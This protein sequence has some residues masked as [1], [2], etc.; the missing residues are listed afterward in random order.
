MTTIIKKDPLLNTNTFTQSKV[1]AYIKQHDEPEWLAE[2][3]QSA[4]QAFIEIPMPTIQDEAWRRTNLRKVK[5]NKFAF[6]IPSSLNPVSE[7]S[8]LP[9]KLRQYL[10]EGQATAGRLLIINGQVIYRELSN[11]IVEQGLLFSDLQ[12]AIKRHA[13]LVQ[14]HLMDKCVPIDDSKFAAL[15]AAFW[16]NGVFLYVPQGVLVKHP[17]QV[18]ILT[19]GESACSIHRTLIIAESESKVDYIEETTTMNEND[20]G[21]NVGMVE[22]IAK[23]A[24]QVRYVDVQQLGSKVYNFNTKRALVHA[25]A[26]MIWDMGEFGGAISKT[27][28]DSQLIGDGGTM[29]CYGVYLLDGKQ[30]LDID[31]LMRHVG[32]STSGDLLLHGALKDKARSVF[33]GLIKIDPSGQL[34]NSYLKNQSLL[35]DSTAR[36]DAI[37]ALEIE[38]DDVRASHAATIS[39]VEDEYIFYLQSRGIL[40]DTAVQM[41]VDGFFSTVFDKMGN[42]RVRE[43]LM[44][45]VRQKMASY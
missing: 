42:E 8:E 37:P 43:R 45:T 1:R 16:Q 24:S 12:T 18:S 22:I 7:L 38:A 23:D 35:L 33:I 39:K 31:S 4:W 20:T 44:Q 40:H 5:W 2:K 25:D 17:F 29:E 9:K 41:V 15:N 30:H 26:N 10:D 27:F 34:T 19:D 3:R 36:A 6:D 11:D 28:I 32:Y 14:P 13:D 21:L